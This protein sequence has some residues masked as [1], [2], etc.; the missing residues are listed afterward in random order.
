MPAKLSPEGSSPIHL[1]VD[2]VQLAKLDRSAKRSG[3]NLSAE[4]RQLIDFGLEARAIE[5]LAATAE[6][7]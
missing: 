6:G 7:S 2:P 3:K 5:R 1:R 4:I